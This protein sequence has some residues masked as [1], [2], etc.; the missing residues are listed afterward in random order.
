MTKLIT[1]LDQ[2]E[3]GMKPLTAKKRAETLMEGL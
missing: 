3:P 2:L 1:S